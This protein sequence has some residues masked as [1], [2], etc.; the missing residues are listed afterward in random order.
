MK[1][2]PAPKWNEAVDGLESPEDWVKSLLPSNTVFPQL[3]QIWEA[4]QDC[5]LFCLA[6]FTWQATE[7]HMVMLRRGQKVRVVGVLDPLHLRFV[8][9]EYDNLEN[10]LMPESARNVPGYTGYDMIGTTKWFNEVFQLETG[11]A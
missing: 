6:H 11:A 1:I 2:P 9:V 5:D 7:A 4:V 10:A 3:G 8:P